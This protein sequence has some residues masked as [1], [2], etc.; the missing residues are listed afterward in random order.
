MNRIIEE[1]AGLDEIMAALDAQSQLQ[2]SGEEPQAIEADDMGRPTVSTAHPRG[3]WNI[4]DVSGDDAQKARN[5]AEWACRKHQE[6]DDAIAAVVEAAD[7]QVAQVRAWQQEQTRKHERRAEWFV[8]VLD[9]YQ[10]DFAPEEKTTK[11]V[12]GKIVRRDMPP[13]KSTNEAECLEWALAREDVDALAPRRLA[14]GEVNKCLKKQADGSYADAD[15]GEVVPFM[16]E[17]ANPIPY[18]VTVKHGGA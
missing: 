14:L 1:G 15:T 17:T 13:C 2:N 3:Y 16:R 6:A 9:L 12:A 7:A 18:K 10:Q 11:L 4:R 5:L 8:G